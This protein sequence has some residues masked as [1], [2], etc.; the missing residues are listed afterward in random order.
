MFR[1][2]R[3]KEKVTDKFIDP[4]IDPSTGKEWGYLQIKP[5]REYTQEEIDMIFRKKFNNFFND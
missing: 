3:R 2:I 1:E 5:E 4:R